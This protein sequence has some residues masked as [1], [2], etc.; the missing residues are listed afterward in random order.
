MRVLHAVA[1]AGVLPDCCP[2]T[3]RSK[4]LGR[5]LVAQVIHSRPEMEQGPGPAIPVIPAPGSE[6]VPLVVDLDRALLRGDMLAE[7][8]FAL[9]F[10]RIGQ[11]SSKRGQ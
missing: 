10:L 2:P 4:L 7:G 11:W 6:R 9:G 1:P 3:I 8:V 5:S